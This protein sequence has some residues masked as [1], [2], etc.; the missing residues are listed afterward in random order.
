MDNGLSM[1]AGSKKTLSDLAMYLDR[2]AARGV[3]SFLL[4][5]YASGS[6]ADSISEP[7]RSL[8]DICLYFDSQY[9]WYRSLYSLAFG[10]ER[11]QEIMSSVDLWRW[12]LPHFAPLLLSTESFVAN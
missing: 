10:G 12:L 2:T 6:I 5:T 7:Q 1:L 4:D 3:F 11:F 9:E 8:L